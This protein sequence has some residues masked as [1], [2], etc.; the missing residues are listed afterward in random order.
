M[1]GLIFTKFYMDINTIGGYSK[2]CKISGSHGGECGYGFAFWDV[3][4]C[5]LV[6]VHQCFTGAYS[7]IIRDISKLCAKKWIMIWEKVRQS[8]SLDGPT[9]EEGRLG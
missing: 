7:F 9:G 2:L 3:A 1:A 4:L 6:E 5:S 8:R